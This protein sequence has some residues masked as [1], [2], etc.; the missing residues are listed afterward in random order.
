MD[1]FAKTVDKARFRPKKLHYFLVLFLFMVISAVNGY[2]LYFVVELVVQPQNGVW[3]M[4]ETT[5]AEP[6]LTVSDLAARFRFS[7]A[8]IRELAREGTIPS[9]CIGGEHRFS[10]H[11][12]AEFLKSRRRHSRLSS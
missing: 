3:K 1:N 11:E 5:P 8:Y 9:F 12:V 6:L 2:I 7:D 10:E 4:I